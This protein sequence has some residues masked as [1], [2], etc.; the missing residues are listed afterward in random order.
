M[1]CCRLDSAENGAG[2][3]TCGSHPLR[4]VF[5]AYLEEMQ[6]SLHTTRSDVGDRHPPEAL[7]PPSPGAG[8]SLAPRRPLERW[9]TGEVRSGRCSSQ[10]QQ[11]GTGVL[12][13]P[14]SRGWAPPQ[15]PRPRS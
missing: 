6:R 13:T 2:T 7:P 8:L 1:F 12:V 5:E 10:G 14:S 15:K 11:T 3:P 9:F 4:R